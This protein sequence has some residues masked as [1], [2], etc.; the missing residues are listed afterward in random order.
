MKR[1]RRRRRMKREEDGEEERVDP[2]L[3]VACAPTNNL[4]GL[5]HVVKGAEGS[6]MTPGVLGRMQLQL[7]SREGDK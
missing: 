4:H 7:S 1:G 6:A 2:L 5:P 3:Q